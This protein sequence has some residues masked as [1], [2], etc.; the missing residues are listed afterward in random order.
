MFANV[1]FVQNILRKAIVCCEKI[2][3]FWKTAEKAQL[4]MQFFPCAAHCL[5]YLLESTAW[6]H[7]TWC[8][9]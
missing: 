1:P 8:C 3:T 9:A 2:A 6:P 5:S 4:D 7:K